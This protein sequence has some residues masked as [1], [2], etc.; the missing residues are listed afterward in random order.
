MACKCMEGILGDEMWDLDGDGPM[1]GVWDGCKWDNNA[2][3]IIICEG[4]RIVWIFM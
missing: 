2:I 1:L 3:L 4:R